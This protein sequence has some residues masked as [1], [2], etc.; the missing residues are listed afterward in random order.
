MTGRL[1]VGIPRQSDTAIC[2]GILK[3]KAGGR[4]PWLFQR[5]TTPSSPYL[6]TTGSSLQPWSSYTVI[7]CYLFRMP[8]F[9]VRA[10]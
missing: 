8:R 6:T 5:F 9:M 1:E 2:A 3:L 7:P 4:F 10:P